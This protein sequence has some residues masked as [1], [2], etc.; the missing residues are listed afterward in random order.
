VKHL[1]RLLILGAR[2]TA[3]FKG[4]PSSLSAQPPCSTESLHS[5]AFSSESDI[6]DRETG[7]PFLGDWS[8]TVVL[9]LGTSL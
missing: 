3:L 8:L 2:F 6:Q 7:V 9:M 5:P 1:C 4:D